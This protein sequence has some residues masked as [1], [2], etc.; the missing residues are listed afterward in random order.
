MEM[1]P[2]RRKT[3]T[4]SSGFL[5]EKISVNSVTAKDSNLI[6]QISPHIHA[7]S[8]TDLILWGWWGCTVTENRMKALKRNTVNV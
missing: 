2:K 1:V 8:G 3:F 6:S 4:S 5:P 7:H